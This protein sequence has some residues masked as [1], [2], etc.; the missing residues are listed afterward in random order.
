MSKCKECSW[1]LSHGAFLAEESKAKLES[2]KEVEKRATAK[3]KDLE[4]KVKDSKNI[5]ERELKAAE[6]QIAQCKKRADESSKKFAQKKQVGASAVFGSPFNSARRFLWATAE[7]AL[8][9][10]VMIVRD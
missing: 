5:R 9:V 8:I 2:C 4:E 10:N 6:Q 3:V 1:R 7:S